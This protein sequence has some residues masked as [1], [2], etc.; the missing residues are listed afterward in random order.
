MPDFRVSD[1]AANHPKFRV[2]GLAALGLWTAC[3]SWAMGELTDGF[4]PEYYVNSWPSGKRSA[5][6]L[7][8]AGLWT[9]TSRNGL[10]GWQFHDFLDVQRPAETIV[11]ERESARERARKSRRA[12]AERAAHAQPDVHETCT[13]P[14]PSPYPFQGDLGAA[15]P[16]LGARASNAAAAPNLDP[17]N[18]R[19]AKHAHLLPGDPGPKCGGCRDVRAHVEA[20]QPTP[21]ADPAAASRAAFRAAVNA[22]DQCDD[23]GMVPKP[24]GSVVRCP[25]DHRAAS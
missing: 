15:V 17:G 13:T 22:C 21:G 16:D 3:G 18:P 23:L 10:R 11:A 2:A 25:R 19:C 24:D 6:R 8:D 14:Y 1:T 12:H 4:V 5:A 9:E 7:V 20:Q